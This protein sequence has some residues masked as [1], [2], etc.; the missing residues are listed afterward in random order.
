MKE[1]VEKRSQDCNVSARK[2]R[3]L[4]AVYRNF[5]LTGLAPKET[6]ARGSMEDNNCF[7]R[8]SA[9]DKPGP[10]SNN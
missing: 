5:G 1:E 6:S 9:N 3:Y 2:I 4:L 7:R 8:P 10:R